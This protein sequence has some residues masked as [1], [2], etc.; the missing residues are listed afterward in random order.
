MLTRRRLFWAVGSFLTGAGLKK[1]VVVPAAPD[2]PY[3]QWYLW[4]SPPAGCDVGKWRDGIMK[5]YNSG[6]FIL[7]YC[8]HAS[9]IGPDHRMEYGSAGHEDGGPEIVL[10][11]HVSPSFRF[12]IDGQ[13]DV[14]VPSRGS[15]RC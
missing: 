7:T 10:P 15:L 12:A 14:Y 4:L 5:D 6:E 11:L 13:V 2:L 1:T 8:R 9:L 3:P